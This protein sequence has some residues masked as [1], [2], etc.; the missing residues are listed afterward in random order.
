M[1]NQVPEDVV[2]DRFDRM[3]QVLNPI[4]HDVV[5]EQVGKTVWVL[6]E[7]TSKHNACIL[8]GRT[9]Q[10]ILVH[11]AGEKN[12]IGQMV[13]VKITENKTFYAIAERIIGE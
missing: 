3:L 5:Q 8:T 1:E 12:L 9:E 2:K 13:P 10:N 6:A 11:F 4:V 7:E